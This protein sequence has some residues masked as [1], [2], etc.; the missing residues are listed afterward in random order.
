[1]ITS[2]L[3]AKVGVWEVQNFWFICFSVCY[4]LSISW[5]KWLAS[6]SISIC[7]MCLSFCHS[8]SCCD[9]CCSTNVSFSN[10]TLRASFTLLFVVEFF[11][12]SILSTATLCT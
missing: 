11:D 10:C 7:T 5:L 4:I 9:N 1:V 6:W 12:H 8:Y 3:F 2:T